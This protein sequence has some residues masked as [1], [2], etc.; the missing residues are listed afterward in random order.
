M[1]LERARAG[2]VDDVSAR[3][4]ALFLRIHVETLG[5][6]RRRNPPLGPPWRKGADGLGMRN[7]HVSYSFA[8][9]V[10]WK[11]AQQ[12][13]THKQRRLT[14]ELERQRL[15][16]AELELELAVAQAKEK[17]AKLA[18]ALG[19]VS[20]FATL[21]D[22]VESTWWATDGQ[23][24]MGHVLTVDDDALTQALDRDWMVEAS[25]VEALEFP[26]AHSRLREP[27]A[28]AAQTTLGELHSSLVVAERRQ[29]EQDL[30]DGLAPGVPVRRG[31]GDRF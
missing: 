18:K 27:F 5:Q 26:W 12:G 23:A 10:A 20:R 24:I 2:M 15:R 14:D 25:L 29:R 13:K 4:A 16:L 22:M 19:R 11:E 31:G 8:E 28:D 3:A 30:E 6:W 7:E 9:L 21:S 17:A 1:E